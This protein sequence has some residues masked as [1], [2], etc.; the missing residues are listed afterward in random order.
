MIDYLKIYKNTL[1]AIEIFEE[2]IASLK[3]HTKLILEQLNYLK[4]EKSN[5]PKDIPNSEFQGSF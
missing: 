3:V 4:V 5:L 1:H 2:V